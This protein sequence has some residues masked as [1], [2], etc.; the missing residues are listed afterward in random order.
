MWDPAVDIM[1]KFEGS[2]EI[3]FI[4]NQ[5]QS[6]FQVI[7][8]MKRSKPEQAIVR[9]HSLIEHPQG[10]HGPGDFTVEVKHQVAWAGREDD[11]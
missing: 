7:D 8:A 6:L 9:Y 5:A 11:S 10:Q 2:S 3:V 4:D 1:W